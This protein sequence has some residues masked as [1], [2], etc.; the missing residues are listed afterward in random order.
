MKILYLIENKPFPFRIDGAAL[1]AHEMLRALKEVGHDSAAI[2]G[3]VAHF[4]PPVKSLWPACKIQAVRPAPSGTQ[5]LFDHYALKLSS[6]PILDALASD[7]EA[8]WVENSSHTAMQVRERPTA[9]WVHSELRKDDELRRMHKNG[10]RLIV[11]S[12]YMRDRVDRRVGVESHVVFPVIYPERVLAEGGSRDHVTFVNP[13]VV[14]GCH[15]FIEMARHMPGVRFQVGE[16]WLIQH[17]RKDWLDR[18]LHCLP[19]VTVHHR[20]PDVRPLYAATRLLV[21]PSLW[22]EAHGRVIREAQINGI[23]VIASRR[24]GIPEAMG[25]GG[26]LVDD[27]T[28]PEAR[29]RT[30]KEGLGD[31]V[32]QEEMV[33]AGY[34]N[35]AKPEF[36]PKNAAKVF[37]DLLDDL[38]CGPPGDQ[39]TWAPREDGTVPR[40]KKVFAD[41]K[42]PKLTKR[43]WPEDMITGP[44][45]FVGLGAQR[46]GTSTW[47]RLLSQHPQIF[48]PTDFAGQLGRERGQGIKERHFFERFVQHDWIPEYTDAYHDIFPRLPGTI[49]G[50]WTACLMHS[51]WM[52]PLLQKAAPD[53][54][55]LVSLRDPVERYISG[56]AYIK[57]RIMNMS[58]VG[59]DAFARGLYATQMEN[60]LKYF[61]RRQVLVLQFERNIQDPG[62]QLNKT[63]RHLGVREILPQKLD[64]IIN[65]AR[66]TKRDLKELRRILVD[67]YAPEVA[68][69][70]E[71]FPDEIDLSL[72]PN[73]QGV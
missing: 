21:M 28:N 53:A 33:A 72:W 31:R 67:R 23:P 62:G 43:A 34:E 64:V 10:I 39:T 68:R 24:G 47:F 65:K 35:A 25:A 61:P 11:P 29:I 4:C 45:D 17:E 54:K 20:S 63:H 15:T 14:K 12:T 40:A 56:L 8:I 6:L 1:S 36:Q 57:N 66:G 18:D 55:I 71:L 37:A 41:F 9:L 7:A 48:V 52:L 2:S 70:K 46:C 26:V 5:I 16:S 13:H 60:V 30:V 27:Y 49:T 58:M 73:F 22:E 51:W 50:E 38:T 19:N 44:P 42:A 3:G 69:L 32:R 59:S